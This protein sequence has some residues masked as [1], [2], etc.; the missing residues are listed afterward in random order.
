MS[1]DFLGRE[2]ELRALDAAWSASGGSLIPVYGRRRIGKS[3][4]LLRFMERRR[5]LYFLGKQAPAA[6]QIHEF[7]VAAARAL[8]APLLAELDVAGG[9]KRALVAAVG[10]WKGEGKLVLAL[11]EFQWM[12]EASPELPSMLQ[13]LWDREWKRSGRVQLLLCG[14]YIGFM[15]R[16][17]LGSRSPLFG[18][19]TAQIHLGPFGLREARLFHP[20]WSLPDVARARF[21][22]G[23]VP[24]YLR[25]LDPR[26]SFRQNL[27]TSVLQEYAPLFRE[28]EFLL[29][30]ELRDMPRYSAVLASLAEG[31]LAAG[32]VA[33]RSGVAAG[34]VAYYLG[35][36]EALGYVERRQRMS[37]GEPNA[38][39]ARWCLADPL[40]RFWYRFVFPNTTALRQLGAERM[41]AEIVVPALPAWEGLA[42]ES[43]CR[44]ALPL[45]YDE[46]GALPAEVGEYWDASM[47]VDVVGRRADRWLDLGECKWGAVGSRR[48]LVDGLRAKAQQ[49]PNP[50]NRT[51]GLRVFARNGIDPDEAARLGVRWHGLDDLYGA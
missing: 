42:F 47:Q 8:E 25:A 7:L 6:I 11:D 18:R 36:L 32:T 46:E 14:S 13:E 44:E 19:R 26:R 41:L 31:P 33:A 35:Q 39:H 29:R 17:V 9:W 27:C 24:M 5:G 22:A 38:R 40:L 1:E 28:P 45:L 20:A 23:G 49:F 48:A 4:L 34:S 37:D 50:T 15:E 43:L 16:E 51:I 12:V 21:V 30:E 2:R 3:E 10:A